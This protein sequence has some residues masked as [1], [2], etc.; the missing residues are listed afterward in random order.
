MVS[1]DHQD[2]FSHHHVSMSYLYMNYPKKYSCP[3]TFSFLLKYV[4]LFAAKHMNFLIQN[5]GGV[6]YNLSKKKDHRF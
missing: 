4:Y 6:I 1:G 2:E 5:P 3:S